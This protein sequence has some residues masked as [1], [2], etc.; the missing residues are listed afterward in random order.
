MPG[1]STRPS[2][3]CSPRWSRRHPPST[4]ITTRRSSCQDWV[5]HCS[6]AGSSCLR[7]WRAI[8][9]PTASRSKYRGYIMNAVENELVQRYGFKRD[10]IG[11]AGL[12]IVT[13]FSKRKT[14][15]LYWAVHSART[16][17]QQYGQP[18]PWYAHVGVILEN[19]KTGGIEASYGGPSYTAKHCKKLYCMLD[20][21]MQ[22]RN[23]VGSSF[24]P[25]VLAAAVKQGMNV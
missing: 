25:Y 7:T 11:S 4:P 20:M 8:P 5:T 1:N 23:Q 22:S 10:Q 16:M 9:C 15:A 24:K 19:P 2:R 14:A 17:M 21:A 18:L 3:R 13:T 6:T 12:H